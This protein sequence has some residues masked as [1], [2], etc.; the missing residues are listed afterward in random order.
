MMLT[1]CDLQVQHIPAVGLGRFQFFR[2]AKELARFKQSLNCVALLIDQGVIVEGMV[3]LRG[4]PTLSVEEQFWVATNWLPRVSPP[5]LAHVA[6]V[7]PTGN[8]YNQH[9]IE[10][11]HRN[12][13]HYIGY[14]VQFFSEPGSALDWLL[15]YQDPTAQAAIEQ[16]WAAHFMG[17]PEAAKPGL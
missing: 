6:F 1:F 13:R 2:P 7:M 9:V 8:S 17:E 10:W 5:P 3:D 11:L 12:A 4:L 15:S 16:E 14:E